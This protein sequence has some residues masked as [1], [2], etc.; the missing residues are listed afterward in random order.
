M[1]RAKQINTALLNAARTAREEFFALKIVEQANKVHGR[2]T[3][4]WERLDKAIK[5]AEA[6]LQKRR[7]E[8]T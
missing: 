1:A 7:D 5:D 8:G 4:A 2:Y 6:E 3:D